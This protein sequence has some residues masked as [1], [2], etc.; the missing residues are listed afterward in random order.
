VIGPNLCASEVRATEV[1]AAYTRQAR[2]AGGCRFRKA[3]L[4]CVS[5]LC[6][7]TPCRLPGLL[8]GMPLA[9]LVSSGAQRRWR[10][11]W[12]HHYATV[13]NH[14]NHPTTSPT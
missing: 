3:P 7:Q 12:A 6:V 13:P 10:Q 14:I 4:V 5:A 11:H 1:I 2:V 9:W 8:M